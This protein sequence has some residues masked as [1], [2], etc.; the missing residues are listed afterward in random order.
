MVGAYKSAVPADQSVYICGRFHSCSSSRGIRPLVSKVCARLFC[1]G[2]TCLV[3]ICPNVLMGK[4]PGGKCP[5]GYIC[6]WGK[7][8]GGGVMS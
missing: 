5:G 7:C 2:G 3:G 8:Q 1:S 6:S 4:C